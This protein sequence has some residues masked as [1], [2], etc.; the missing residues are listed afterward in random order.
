MKKLAGAIAIAGVVLVG[1]TG[2]ITIEPQIEAKP[3]AVE[4]Q[5]EAVETPETEAIIPERP[6]T[7]SGVI[8]GVFD[9]MPTG[10]AI[11]T[12]I[13]SGLDNGVPYGDILVITADA[14]T[15]ECPEHLEALDQYVAESR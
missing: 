15:F 13:D 4:T 7:M 2:C 6:E 14:L 3:E 9:V 12:V 5:P 1:A 8:C 10:E 11:D